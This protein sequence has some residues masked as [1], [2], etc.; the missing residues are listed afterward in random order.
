MSDH[1][2]HSYPD[3]DPRNNYNLD[4]I[5]KMLELV[6]EKLGFTI[7]NTSYNG[8]IVMDPVG[9]NLNYVADEKGVS[10]NWRDRQINPQCFHNHGKHDGE[11]FRSGDEKVHWKRGPIHY[12]YNSWRLATKVG[13]E[14]HDAVHWW[15][16]E[17][18]TTALLWKLRIYV[19]IL[20]VLNYHC[21]EDFYCGDEVIVQGPKG[22][23]VCH[24]GYMHKSHGLG[25]DWQPPKPKLLRRLPDYKSD[26]DQRD[27]II[28]IF[29]TCTRTR[30]T[31][32]NPYL[33]N[34]Q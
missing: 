16:L 27:E 10:V 12:T 17:D 33:I 1:V 18:E 23:N 20:K 25:L 31:C 8:F 9:E 14:E 26:D 11:R 28:R 7:R 22:I 4:K 34:L 29:G 3:E 13:F 21:T 5:L 2:D 24:S 30:I 32:K 19:D 15:Q 6:L